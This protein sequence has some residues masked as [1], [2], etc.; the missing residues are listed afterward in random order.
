MNNSYSGP[1]TYYS[2]W[3]TPALQSA[4][5]DHPVVVLTGARQVGKS[6]L[7]LNA[8]PFNTWR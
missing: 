3:L 4:V 2:R 7:L 5:E 1:E 6:T 8:A